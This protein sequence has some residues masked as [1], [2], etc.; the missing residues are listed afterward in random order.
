MAKI[1]F[2]SQI[3]NQT[4]IMGQVIDADYHLSNAQP[5]QY[6]TTIFD[7]RGPDVPADAKKVTLEIDEHG[8]VKCIPQQ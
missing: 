1:T 7:I 4:D 3:L 2:T 5:G 6:D 8:N